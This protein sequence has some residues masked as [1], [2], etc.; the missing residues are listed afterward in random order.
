MKITLLTALFLASPVASLALAQEPTKN[1][2]QPAKKSAAES[3]HMFAIPPQQAI[4]IL[5]SFDNNN[6]ADALNFVF[7]GRDLEFPSRQPGARQARAD[8]VAAGAEDGDAAAQS[9]QSG[10]RDESGADDAAA[11]PDAETDGAEPEAKPAP[12]EPSPQ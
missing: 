9:E 2:P 11:A 8:A 3:V 1:R 5:A 4:S 7:N 10:A 12:A 6:R